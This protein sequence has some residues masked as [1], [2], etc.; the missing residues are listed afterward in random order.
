AGAPVSFRRDGAVAWTLAP[1]GRVVVR[2][3]GVSGVGHTVELERGSIR[4]EVTP[5]DPAEGLIEAFAVEVENTRGAVHGT[6]F[7][8]TRE[9]DSVIVDVEHGSVAVGPK[10]H[11]GVTTGHLL[12]GPKRAAFSLDGGRT[13]RLLPRPAEEPPEHAALA[14]EPPSAPGEPAV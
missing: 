8:V 12:V 14:V 10:G 2:S 6:A 9:G 11:V 13:A 1:R 5:R 7:S 4:A 3:L